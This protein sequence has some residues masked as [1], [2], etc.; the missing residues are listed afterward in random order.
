MLNCIKSSKI[1][2]QLS[3]RI[4]LMKYPTRLISSLSQT[5]IGNR[6]WAATT[7]GMGGWSWSWS[8]R[9]EVTPSEGCAEQRK[10]RTKTHP[11]QAHACH[12][13]TSREARRPLPWSSQPAHAA[14]C[15]SCFLRLTPAA[16]SASGLSSSTSFA[17]MLATMGIMEAPTEGDDLTRILWSVRSLIRKKFL[18]CNYD[19]YGSMICI[20]W[21]HWRVYLCFSCLNSTPSPPFSLPLPLSLLPLF[22][23]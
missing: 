6:K 2:S 7:G 12:P 8:H 17:A 18:Q 9:C 4:S 22:D 19:I 1:T 11:R 16:P 5:K 21:I 13:R 14:S 20:S 3:P 15:M 23:M 10:K